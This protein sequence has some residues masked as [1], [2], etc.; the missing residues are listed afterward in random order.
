MLLSPDSPQLSL[1]ETDE[2]NSTKPH[3]QP[4]LLPPSRTLYHSSLLLIFLFPLSLCLEER[5]ATLLHSPTFRRCLFASALPHNCLFLTSAK[6]CCFS[7]S[8]AC[9]PSLLYVF[10]RPSE[11]LSEM[12]NSWK[13]KSG[14]TDERG[15]VV[16]LCFPFAAISLFSA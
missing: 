8:S 14:Q 3:V 6:V 1:G 12:T 13:E 7:P 4:S 2:E 15:V 9:L 16:C 5:D 10:V 11:Q